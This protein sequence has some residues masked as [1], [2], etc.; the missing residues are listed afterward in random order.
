MLKDDCTGLD[1]WQ[2]WG[3]LELRS[4]MSEVDYPPSLQGQGHL[5]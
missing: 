1:N 3:S 2:P 5:L 4:A